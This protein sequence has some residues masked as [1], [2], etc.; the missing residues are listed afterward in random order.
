MKM[1]AL[2][3]KDLPHSCAY[4]IHGCDSFFGNEFLCDKHGVTKMG[5]SCRHYRY[6]PLKRT[7]KKAKP[8]DGYDPEDFSL[9]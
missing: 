3:N 5:D 6:D 7:P 4:C 8:A 9:E 1:S 2:F